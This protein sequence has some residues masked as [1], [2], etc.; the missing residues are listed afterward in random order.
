MIQNE[1]ETATPLRTLAR[2]TPVKL[3]TLALVNV[4]LLIPLFR[5]MFLIDE[6]SLRQSEAA[7]EVSATWSGPQTLVGPILAVPYVEEVTPSERATQA[8]LKAGLPPPDATYTTWELYRLPKELRWKGTVEPQVRSR[9]LFEAVVY[10]ATLEAQGTFT[11]PDWATTDATPH[12]RQRYDKAYLVLSLSELRG[13]A[14]RVTLRWAGV[15][16][17]FQ[18]GTKHMPAPSP[19][20]HVPLD[21][22]AWPPGTTIPF[23]IRIVR[24]GSQE[25]RFFPGG[26]ETTV[27]LSSPWPSPGFVGSF[28]PQ[29]RRLGEQGFEARW[30]LTHLGRVVPQQWVGRGGGDFTTDSFGVRLVIPADAYQKAERSIKYGL[31]FIFLTTLTFFLVELISPVRLSAIHYLLVGLA[32]V[33][34]YL[35]LLALGEHLSFG[36]AYLLAAVA[37]TGLIAA[38]ARSL[39]GS[40]PWALALLAALGSLYGYLYGLVQAEDLSLLMGAIGL[41]V[42]LATVMFLTRKLDWRSLR[43]VP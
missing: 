30:G 37:C 12:G 21:L 14:E 13:V 19:G 39:F 25:L 33:L 43:F 20:L 2:S 16:H 18:P 34:F 32:L 3:L 31:L 27:E 8:A 7:R 22:S 6:R 28:L 17:D 24:R 4:I 23:E 38:Y 36:L 15:S 26:E 10:Q 9:G 40:G 42:I 35:L 29:E 1:T 41:F 11:A 5:V